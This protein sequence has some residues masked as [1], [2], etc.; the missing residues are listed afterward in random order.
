MP[1]FI[2]ALLFLSSCF[3][4]SDSKPKIRFVDS[5][6]NP[7]N[8]EIKALEL[9][10]RSMNQQK[11]LQETKSD[12]KID[13][14]NLELARQNQDTLSNSA[15]S[16]MANST[17]SSAS[18]A[19]LEPQKFYN[20]KQQEQDSSYNQ[21]DANHNLATATESDLVNSSLR[22]YGKVDL[23][24]IRDNNQQ[25]QKSSNS[26]NPISE[27]DA[28]LNPKNEGDAIKTAD[29]MKK[30]IVSAKYDSLVLPVEEKS[31]SSKKDASTNQA[32][33]LFEIE[34]PDS[35]QEKSSA[36]Y[37]KSRSEP[38][39][40]YR[41]NSTNK[42]RSNGKNY[43]VQLGSFL[44]REK[45]KNLIAKMKE[46]SGGKIEEVQNGDRTVYRALI[47]PFTNKTE[48]K[49]IVR[50]IQQNGQDAVLVKSN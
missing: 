40:N 10:S 21:A 30:E 1:I 12:P 29:T 31:E 41:D 11:I 2:L 46:Y 36:D 27:N 18:T 47:G 49:S 7:K 25:D 44:Q 28:I 23:K 33:I 17:N 6:G 39:K 20:L 13:G 22:N 48:A 14:K 43:Y 19:I 50:E 42:T 16:K 26:T 9:N 34:K 3:A 32:E 5:K 4:G 24:A 38:P 15:N 8:L 37:R 35:K 45:A